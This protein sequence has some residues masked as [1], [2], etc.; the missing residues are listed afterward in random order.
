MVHRGHHCLL[1]GVPALAGLHGRCQ[2]GGWTPPCTLDSERPED[3][4]SSRRYPSAG[5][6]STRRVPRSRVAS[7]CGESQVTSA[8]GRSRGDS[9]GV[10]SPAP[11]LWGICFGCLVPTSTPAQ[12]GYLTAA[13][14]SIPKKGVLN[15]T[16]VGMTRSESVGCARRHA[17]V[18]APCRLLY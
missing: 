4:F 10:G 2:A 13:C 17:V 1:E 6:C 8:C 12:Q 18:P 9:A 3:R 15:P 16:N 14:S 5:S 7:A 11:R